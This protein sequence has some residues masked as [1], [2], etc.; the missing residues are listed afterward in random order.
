[1]TAAGQSKCIVIWLLCINQVQQ[2]QYLSYTI[3]QDAYQPPT[4]RVQT[5]INY[6]QP[7]TFQELRFL[8]VIN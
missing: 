3:N 8:G 2:V 6:K 1:M 4:E 7:E 5:I